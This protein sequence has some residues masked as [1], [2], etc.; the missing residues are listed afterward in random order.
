MRKLLAS[1]GS[2]QFSNH[3]MI[4]C[5]IAK[6]KILGGIKT[7]TPTLKTS[8]PSSQPWNSERRKT[9]QKISFSCCNYIKFTR[10]RLKKIKRFEPV[11]CYITDSIQQKSGVP[12]NS[13]LSEPKKNKSKAA[14]VINQ[15]LAKSIQ[16][17][18]I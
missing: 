18:H 5:R 11:P 2:N 14:R 8:I 16:I 9:P 17:L 3:S 10:S 1:L 4:A 12:N 13:R 6:H 7:Y 15:N